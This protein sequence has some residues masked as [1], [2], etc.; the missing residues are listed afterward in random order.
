MSGSLPNY[1]ST[2]LQIPY[3]TVSVSKR[4]MMGKTSTLPLQDSNAGKAMSILL[5]YTGKYVK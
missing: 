2:L 1:S 3:F 5:F 4:K